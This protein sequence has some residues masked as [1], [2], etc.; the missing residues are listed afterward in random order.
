MFFA[1]YEMDYLLHFN[2]EISIEQMYSDENFVT[3]LKINFYSCVYNAIEF[4]TQSR[5]AIEIVKQSA[6]Y[7]FFESAHSA[8][9]RFGKSIRPI[10]YVMQF[11]R[12]KRRMILL[13][14][15]IA[16]LI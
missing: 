14:G 6:A 2:F 16:H 11:I 4:E 12:R 3:A 13:C 8:N 10:G 9:A 15:Y 1:T 5:T 7:S